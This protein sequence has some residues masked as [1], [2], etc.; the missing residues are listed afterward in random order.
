MSEE[1]LERHEAN[2]G[3]SLMDQCSAITPTAVILSDTW[4]I[5]VFYSFR[6]LDTTTKAN[7]KPIFERRGRAM[8]LVLVKKDIRSPFTSR[9]TIEAAFL[10]KV[11]H[12]L[13][14]PLDPKWSEWRSI[15]S[16]NNVFI[17]R[18]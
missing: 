7:S 2:C 6:G 14:G 3:R 13:M 5:S 15:F 18:P 10:A 9:A 16:G 17:P 8:V 1:D 11:F 4:H 12:D